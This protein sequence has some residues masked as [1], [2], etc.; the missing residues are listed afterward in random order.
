LLDARGSFTWISPI[1][2]SSDDEDEVT[3]KGLI[4]LAGILVVF[5][6]SGSDSVGI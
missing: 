4:V 2:L 3:S 6:F 1:V 5:S